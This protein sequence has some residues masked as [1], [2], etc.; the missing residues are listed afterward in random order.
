MK[1]PTDDTPVDGEEDESQMDSPISQ[2][3]LAAKKQ[4]CLEPARLCDK[5]K[6]QL[7]LPA[8]L[9]ECERKG[10]DPFAFMSSSAL[11]MPVLHKMMPDAVY[12]PTLGGDF[13]PERNGR[14]LL[15]KAGCGRGKS[16][17]FREYMTRVLAQSTGAR[18]LLLSANI[19]YGSNLAAELKKE[20][21][22]FKVGFYKEEAEVL[23]SCQV[24]V[25][26]LESLH[27]IAN[28]RFEML[29]IDEARTIGGLV[30]GATMPSFDTVYA[31]RQLCCDT[32]R[33]VMCDADLLFK[34]DET[35][36]LPAGIDFAD[37][38]LG[39]VRSA[40]CANLTH[41][42]PPHLKRSARLFYN[43]ESAAV[44]K[45][46]WFA[47]IEKAAAAW[48]ENHECRFAISVGSKAQLSEVC[49][50]LKQLKVP[51]KP[52]SG[53]T[54]QDSKLIDLQEPDEA[55]IEF[56]CIPSTTS[57]SI[58]VDPKTVQF[59][60]VFIWTHR[61]GCNVLT[62]F[63][64]AMRYGRSD[65]A[66]L[67][68]PTVDILL[69]CRP[70][71]VVK[72]LVDAGKMKATE[73]PTFQDQL[74]YLHKRRGSRMRMHVQAMQAVG[75]HIEG[76]RRVQHVTDT[77]LRLMAHGRLERAMQ[78]SC[79][80]EYVLRICEHHG[81]DIVG[82]E[83][84][85]AIK[86]DTSS[87]PDI[88]I[89]PDDEFCVEWTVDEKFEWALQQVTERGEAGF[90]D[91]CY[92]MVSQNKKEF[93]G[94]CATAKLLSKDQFLVKTYWLL[95][96]FERMPDEGD[97]GIAQLKELDENGV[98][99]GL[100]LHAHR[101]VF[102][103]DEQDRRDMARSLEAEDGRVAHPMLRV[104]MG[105]R[106]RAIDDLA[107]LLG[108]KSLLDDCTLPQR[109]VDIANREAKSK[110]K[111][112]ESA[113]GEA[114]A[115]ESAGPGPPQEELTRMDKAFLQRFR[116]AAEVFCD[117]EFT[118]PDVLDRV[119]TGCGM[120]LTVRREKR[121]IKPR[122]WF[123]AEMTLSRRLPE[124]M[125]DFLIY[126]HAKEEKVSLA[127]WD[128]EHAAKDEQD[129]V[130]A[131]EADWWEECGDEPMEE[132][133]DAVEEVDPSVTDTREQRTQK[134]DGRALMAKLRE[135]RDKRDIT[136]QEARWLAWLDAADAA[137]MPR[138]ASPDIEMEGAGVG[139][140][141]GDAGPSRSALFVRYL[142]VTYGKRRAIGRRTE[143]H[144]GMQHCPTGL[145][146][147]LVRLFYH[148][149]DLVNCHPT[150]FLQVARK[151]K[152]DP[153]ELGVLEEYVTDR[154]AVL[155]RIGD[156]YGV[157]AAKCKYAVLRIL[158]GGQPSTWIRDAK[159]PLNAKEL[160][161]DLRA[162][163]ELHKFVQAAFFGMERFQSHV[164][165]LTERLRVERKAA[166][167]MA[168]VRLTNARSAEDKSTAQKAI[169]TAK[170][171]VQPSAIRRTV[172]SLC[173][174]ELED[175]ILDVIDRSLKRDGWT[176][177]S[178]QF[179]GCHVEHRVGADLDA[180]MRWA[181][182]AVLR[183]TGY[184][185]QL[186]EKALFECVEEAEE[187]DV[188]MGIEDDD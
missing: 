184:A 17:T 77:L 104:A 62:Q 66:P 162:L 121:T 171:R 134:L 137:A 68:N 80:N 21:K 56:G 27:H 156:F 97:A 85:Q 92:D 23:S 160:Q 59:A 150:L 188:L 20:L 29:L 132:E 34:V 129:M 35:E 153:E 8:K 163:V 106:M 173:V 179:D 13:K 168:E 159:C 2:A 86:L 40:V 145:R 177:A 83:A 31:L 107:D 105:P 152:V 185:V 9:V 4:R 26:S 139:A 135:L 47:E 149:V 175:S 16:F 28:Q 72:V 118:L 76:A 81:W 18:V 58:G 42:G 124:L 48:H 22:D 90:F 144:P 1:R 115:T 133:G 10:P 141:E 75:G 154:E 136:D 87:L 82:Y 74:K 60:R 172:F 155:K 114:A 146:P 169:A 100:K 6:T 32:P 52:Y 170:R 183:E 120:K 126:S 57:L 91:K 50:F 102:A 187:N 95:Q 53:D 101:R 69:D 174:F 123:I 5:D 122:T 49:L 67:I 167:E 178:L 164:A 166:L 151:M 45:E 30:G 46:E 43:A 11:S 112:V 131:E 138:A 128:T 180:A 89:D 96:P 7:R 93:K 41:P 65:K 116:G 98:L 117:K 157:P 88:Q 161:A 158:N 71:S 36:E 140:A 51:Y 19:L 79:H 109:V 61:M 63:Q 165:M 78:G 12:V 142:T 39:G 37:F 38:L 25:C 108:L 186:K 84:S 70:P 113:D 94:A 33:V 176:V 64:A 148:D 111:K 143:S 181:E 127:D 55:W 182:R 99:P 15:I 54:R 73:R 14:A 110:K 147:Q 119:A 125:H 24:V 44:G 3:R 103:P 130:E